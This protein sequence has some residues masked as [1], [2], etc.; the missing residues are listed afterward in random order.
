VPFTNASGYSSLQ[1]DELLQRATEATT[2]DVRSKVYAQVS[3][4]LAAEMPTLMLF[5]EVGV[6]AARA[7]LRGVWTGGDARDRWDAVWVQK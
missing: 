1:V 2:R 5:D 4:L 3:R 6:D 7:T